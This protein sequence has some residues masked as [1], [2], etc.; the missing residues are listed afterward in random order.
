MAEGVSSGVAYFTK[1]IRDVVANVSKKVPMS[2]DQVTAGKSPKDFPA[3]RVVPLEQVTCRFSGPGPGAA[4][5]HTKTE[6]EPS[7]NVCCTSWDERHE[8]ADGVA[9][10]LYDQ[11]KDEHQR[12]TGE[13]VADVFGIVSY[14]NGALLSVADGVNWGEKPR[15]AARC[16]IHGSLSYLEENLKKATTTQQIIACLLKSFDNAQTLII[17]QNATLTTLVTCCVCQIA[18]G[19]WVVCA[20]NVGDSFAYIYSVPNGTVREVTVY[21]HQGPR[22]MRLAGGTLGPFD[23]YSPDL[24]NLTC[25]FTFVEPDEI[26]FALSDGVYDNFDPV[27]LRMATGPPQPSVEGLPHLSQSERDEDGLRRMGRILQ[28]EMPSGRVQTASD[29]TMALLRHVVGLTEAKRRCFEELIGSHHSD[30]KSRSQ[31][32]PGKLDHATVAAVQIGAFP[33]DPSEEQKHKCETLA[34]ELGNL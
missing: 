13:P 20:V 2:R 27:V 12:S 21:S 8:R 24:A 5:V 14:R 25:S 29:V 1:V 17:K 18:D 6:G 31:Q 10:S 26:L 7:C 16:A 32:L 22:D 11:S 4:G 15:L 9:L 28:E 23:G 3:Y 33:V 30:I 19:R 34:L